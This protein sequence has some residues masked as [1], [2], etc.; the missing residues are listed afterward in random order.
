MRSYLL[1]VL[2]MAG[3]CLSALADCDVPYSLE[4]QNSQEKRVRSGQPGRLTSDTYYTVV[5]ETIEDWR[6]T[7]SGLAEYR[8]FSY[9]RYTGGNSATD[10]SECSSTTTNLDMID[11]PWS[12]HIE[13]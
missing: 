6:K 1:F 4:W 7:S 2:T 11:I 3:F 8:Q 9:K 5:T 12:C 10:C 13:G